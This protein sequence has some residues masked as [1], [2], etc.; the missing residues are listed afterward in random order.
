MPSSVPVPHSALLLL[1]GGAV[2]A[3]GSFL[4]WARMSVLSFTGTSTI[5]GSAT[6]VAGGVAAVLGY[7]IARGRVP[8]RASSLLAM[9]AAAIA[10]V[11]PVVVSGQVHRSILEERLDAHLE[12][13][14]LR[15]A[16]V[17]G[18]DGDSTIFDRYTPFLSADAAQL[19][20]VIEDSMTVRPDLGLRV[21]LAGGLAMSAGA[22][23]TAARRQRHGS[24][25]AEP[26]V[27]TTDTTASTIEVAANGRT[28]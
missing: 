23:V 28:S 13:H 15:A 5:W 22:A 14:G 25:S 17:L 8:G 12:P 1:G 10:V 18:S 20:Q 11:V 4:P 26:D 3:V 6:A 24:A 7:R 16:D 19:V 27:M 2:A 21:T 9:T